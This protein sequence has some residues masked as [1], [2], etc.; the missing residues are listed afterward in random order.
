LAG[1]N[2][3]SRFGWSDG[4]YTLAG[5]LFGVR[6]ANLL[7]IYRHVGGNWRPDW[8]HGIATSPLSMEYDGCRVARLVFC[9]RYGAKWTIED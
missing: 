7:V 3:A 6:S 1:Q 2:W 8:R 9:E 5:N 4:S